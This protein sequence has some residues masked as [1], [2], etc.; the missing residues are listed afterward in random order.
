MRI[1]ICSSFVPFIHGGG[2]FIVDWLAIKLRE[3]G[4]QVEVIYLPFGEKSDEIL[5]QFV[6]YRLLDL[7]QDTDRLIT[8]RPP[9]YLI[10]HP[11]KII[12][13]I[14]QF[15]SFYD[16]WDGPYCSYPDDSKHRAIRTR[17]MEADRVSFGEARRLFTNSQVVSR[18]LQFY[19][20]IDSEV[21][22]P[23]LL[24]PER[25]YCRKY[26]DEVVYMCRVEHHKRQH[27]LVE[28]FRY[29]RTP[30]KLR[31]CGVSSTSYAQKLHTLISKNWL[32][33]RV[34]FENR[35]ISEERE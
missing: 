30:V 16:L 9:A 24:E 29:V 27:L 20:K 13:L 32:K 2:R 8:I 25:F 5:P 17:I 33:D 35:W 21:L 28:A 15:R 34:N 11:N 14:H 22:Y 10:P 26:G 31:I 4:H 3:Y 23:P 12:W 7:T 6:S 19:N 18:R 1:A